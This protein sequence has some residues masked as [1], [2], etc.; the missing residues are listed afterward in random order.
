VDL[1][2][3]LDE[4]EKLYN[5]EGPHIGVNEKLLTKFL[6]KSYN[7]RQLPAEF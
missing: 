3:R 6:E 7:E 2:R 1:D 5:S 4:R